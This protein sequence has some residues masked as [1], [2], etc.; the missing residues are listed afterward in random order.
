MAEEVILVDVPSS[1]LKSETD[2]ESTKASGKEGKLWPLADV[3]T[4]LSRLAD[5]PSGRG[6]VIHSAFVFP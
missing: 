1:S 2:S 5:H 4:D 3:N 6:D